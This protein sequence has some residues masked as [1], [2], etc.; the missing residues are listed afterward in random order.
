MRDVPFK[1]THRR[2]SSFDNL[3]HDYVPNEE[4]NSWFE[5]SGWQNQP[6]LDQ[7]SNQ[8]CTM[9]RSLLSGTSRP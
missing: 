6:K 4:M 5:D 1:Q 8:F 7:F 3:F 2:D 9:P